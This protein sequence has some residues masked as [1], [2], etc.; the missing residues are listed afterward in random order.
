ML[1][2]DDKKFAQLVTGT[3]LYCA[4][5]VDS[6]MLVALSA[7][8]SEQ[9]IPTKKTMDKSNDIFRL[10]SVSRRGSNHIPCK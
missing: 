1:D 5:A 9:A 8:A 10:Y 7:L 6:T 2:K 3:F 4:R